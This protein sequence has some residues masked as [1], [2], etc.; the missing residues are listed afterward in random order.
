MDLRIQSSHNGHLAIIFAPHLTVSAHGDQAKATGQI[1]IF[2]RSYTGQ[3][4]KSGQ[5]DNLLGC[6]WLRFKNLD[7]EFFCLVWFAGVFCP[8]LVS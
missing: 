7:L 2:R 5:A 8:W 3:W 4:A 1:E 6:A